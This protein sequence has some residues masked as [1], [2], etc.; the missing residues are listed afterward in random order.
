MGTVEIVDVAPVL[1]GDPGLQDGV[2]DLPGKEL[3]A[4]LAVEA[5][6]VRDLPG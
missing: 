2:E 6:H 5:F 3:V 4:C 1:V